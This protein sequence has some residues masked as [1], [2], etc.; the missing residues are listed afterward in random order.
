MKIVRN[1]N[2]RLIPEII[3]RRSGAALLFAGLLLLANPLFAEQSFIEYVD[4]DVTIVH[5]EE[6][7]WADFGDTLDPGDLLVAYNLLSMPISKNVSSSVF[8]LVV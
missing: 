2:I 5:G 7:F 3:K 6:E 8:I 4:G 1:R